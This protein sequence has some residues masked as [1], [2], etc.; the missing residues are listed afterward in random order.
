MTVA[1]RTPYRW[2]VEFLSNSDTVGTC[3]INYRFIG[4]MQKLNDYNY[5]LLVFSFVRQQPIH[6]LA[7]LSRLMTH[8]FN[9][10]GFLPFIQ[11]SIAWIQTFY[12]SVIDAIGGQPYR[13]WAGRRLDYNPP[14][15][16][17]ELHFFRIESFRK[18]KTVI[19]M[20]L[21]GDI[22]I[23]LRTFLRSILLNQVM[24]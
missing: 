17:Y 5:P 9:G 24:E 11:S 13:D 12:R 6:S 18:G 23:M 19:K 14:P 10:V 8:D 2:N 3:L 21:S 1:F 4:R 20:S 15:L 7:P 16:Y 22:V